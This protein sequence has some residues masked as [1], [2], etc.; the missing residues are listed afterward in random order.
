[1][2]K[3]FLPH[4]EEKEKIIMLLRRH[5]FVIFLKILLWSATAILPV[6]FYFLMNNFF[7]L[8][9]FNE[10]MQAIFVLTIS[11]YYMYIW[12][13]A[14]Y[15][16]VDYYLDVWI[17]TTERILN[18]EQK[19]LF[20]RQVSEQRLSRIQDVTSEVTGFFPTI[21]DYGTVYIQTAGEQVRFVFKQVPNPRQ[22]AK[23]IIAI[24]EQNRKYH[25]VLEEEGIHLKKN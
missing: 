20:S 19:G 14:F 4:A 2:K 13:F 1:M 10:A 12:L 3:F 8:L 5:W 18:I 16:F 9:I 22:V 24:I 23:K 17:V 11:I 21:L 15:S 25:Q 7:Q 6:I